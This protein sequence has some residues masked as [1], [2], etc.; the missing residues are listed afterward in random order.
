MTLLE[1]QNRSA[2]VV[3]ELNRAVRAHGPE[4]HTFYKADIHAYVMVIQ[5]INRGFAGGSA[6]PTIAL[7]SWRMREY[8]SVTPLTAH[9]SRIRVSCG[10]DCQISGV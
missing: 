5:N 9:P 2:T 6:G 7:P 8:E 4:P 10:M 3:A 1:M